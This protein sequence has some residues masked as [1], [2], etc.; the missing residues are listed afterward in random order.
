LSLVEL[1]L[2]KFLKWHKRM[3]CVL[4]HAF[5]DGLEA[6]MNLLSLHHQRSIFE[7]VCNFGSQHTKIIAVW[8]SKLHRMQFL[9]LSSWI[10][11]TKLLQ[12]KTNVV[13][14]LRFVL[15]NNF[16]SSTWLISNTFYQKQWNLSTLGVRIQT[17]KGTSGIFASRCFQCLLFEWLLLMVMVMRVRF[18]RETFLK[19]QNW[20][21]LNKET[22][23]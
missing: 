10:G 1:C 8:D 11:S 15:E 2:H 7:S 23:I 21:T 3:V 22:H 14:Y 18:F 9:F 13:L 20:S 16:F 4:L 5:Y 17:C 19:A 12:S 6:M